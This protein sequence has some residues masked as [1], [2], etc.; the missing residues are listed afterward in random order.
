MSSHNAI[1]LDYSQDCQPT[2]ELLTEALSH[3][4][5]LTSKDRVQSKVVAAHLLAY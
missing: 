4:P 3:F 2:R 5:V 1:T